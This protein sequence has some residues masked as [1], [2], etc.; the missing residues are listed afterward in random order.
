M[1]Y[2]LLTDRNENGGALGWLCT[3][4]HAIVNKMDN[5]SRKMTVYVGAK[6][7]FVGREVYE[8]QGP[9]LSVKLSFGCLAGL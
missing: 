8:H 2:K 9:R 6:T 5:S 3:P 1:A 7:E 4:L